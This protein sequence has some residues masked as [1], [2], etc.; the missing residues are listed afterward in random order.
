MKPTTTAL[1][2]DVEGDLAAEEENKL[3]N[4]V[5]VHRS[6]RRRATHSRVAAG[7]QDMVSGVLVSPSSDHQTSRVGRKMPRICTIWSSPMRST[8]QA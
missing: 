7:I 1:D 5:G 3:I 6:S 8:G 2:E 4:E